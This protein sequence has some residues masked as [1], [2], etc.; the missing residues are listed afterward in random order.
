MESLLAVNKIDARVDERKSATRTA[1]P[2]NQ[3]AL[4]VIQPQRKQIVFRVG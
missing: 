3:F 2:K 1:T 4:V